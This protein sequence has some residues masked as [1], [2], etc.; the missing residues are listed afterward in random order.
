[1]S[2]LSRVTM[3]NFIH[4]LLQSSAQE[5]GVALGCANGDTIASIHRLV[6]VRLLGCTTLQ[7]HAMTFVSQA[8]NG[9]QVSVR[10]EP[11]G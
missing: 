3:S 6:I 8:M 2:T 9:S 10:L 1:M 5:R 11:A 7:S 4:S